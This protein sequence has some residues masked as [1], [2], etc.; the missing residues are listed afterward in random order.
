MKRMTKQMQAERDALVAKI[1]EARAARHAIRN[2]TP[3]D[4]DA[5]FAASD[6][7]NAASQAV[8]DWDAANGRAPSGN[9]PVFGPDWVKRR[10]AEQRAEHIDLQRRV[11]LAKCR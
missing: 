7:E 3:R 10:V 5:E 2:A 9:R 1:E 11:L 8:W 6:R 4:V